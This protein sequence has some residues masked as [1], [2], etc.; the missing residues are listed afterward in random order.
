MKKYNDIGEL[1]KDNFENFSPEP[2]SK[3]WENVQLK[4]NQSRFP[5]YKAVIYSIASITAISALIFGI[6]YFTS[7]N[8]NEINHSDKI[9]VIS[10]LHYKENL[11]AEKNIEKQ[12][13]NN[14]AKVNKK[15]H[16]LK[17]VLAPSID[18]NQPI[19]TPHKYD[20]QSVEINA[21]EDLETD[22]DFPNNNVYQ[23]NPI[24]VFIEKDTI[25]HTPLKVV[26]SN[27]T[28][29]CENSTITLSIRNA[30]NISWNNGEKSE[31]I[32]VQI[33]NSQY[34]SVSFK[35][36]YGKDT[37]INIF[38]R[39]VPCTELT[40]PTAFTPNGDGLND[41][42]KVY[43][44][45]SVSSFEMIIFNKNNKEVFRTTN[46]NQGWNGCI[47][48]SQ[49]PNGLY[50]YIIHYKDNFNQQIER[51]GEFLLLRN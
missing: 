10:E 19:I 30:K 29:V 21:T 6:I 20:I 27:D 23:H 31:D 14:I 28:T 39:C 1:F 44:S 48:Q 36:Q 15:V 51:K 38:V 24:A 37:T 13:M 12:P 9:T 34:F 32:A 42:F 2:P 5:V 3:V 47:M 43:A 8:L 16:G 4:I 18:Y 41:E 35:N 11:K 25:K 46:L 17:P 45:G 7:K 33:D 22:K 49:Q 40:I 26:V 50:F